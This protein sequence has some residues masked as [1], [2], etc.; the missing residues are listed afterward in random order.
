MISAWSFETGASDR[1]DLCDTMC[2]QKKR[3]KPVL[4]SQEDT[5]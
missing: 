4:W 3:L 2:E 5:I 1:D